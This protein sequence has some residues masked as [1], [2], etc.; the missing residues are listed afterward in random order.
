MLR[1][2]MVICLG[3]VGLSLVGAAGASAAAGDVTLVSVAP[4]GVLANAGSFTPSVSADGCRVA[5]LTD[6]TNLIPG[7]NS[8][9]LV[10]RDLCAGI[11][12][13]VATRV[14]G[15]PV[16]SAD[17]STVA[18]QTTNALDPLDTNADTDIYTV[19]VDTGVVQWVSAATNGGFQ[20][21]IS[22]DGRYVA[23]ISRNPLTPADTNLANDVF[24]RDTASGTT[25][26]ASTND[27]GD[28]ANAGRESGS[29]APSISGDGRYVAFASDAT[30]LVPNDTNSQPDVF[31]RDMS[32]HTTVRANVSSGGS[33]AN[34]NTYQPAISGNGHVVAFTSNATNLVADDTN[35][36]A[37]VFVRDLAAQT[38]QR[39]SVSSTGGQS[40][41][42]GSNTTPSLSSDGRFVAF[43]GGRG[44]FPNARSGADV[45]VRDRAR[46]V[47][48]WVSYSASKLNAGPN[49]EFARSTEPMISGNGS[50][51]VFGNNDPL[52]P[53]A[54]GTQNNVWETQ[55]WAS[56]TTPP[57]ITAQTDPPAN[58]YGWYGEPPTI[59]WQ[60]TD[61]SGLAVNPPASMAGTEGEQ[62]LY[63]SDPG[64]DLIGNCATGSV[65]LSS[66][67][68]IPSVGDPSF[69]PEKKTLTGSVTISADAADTPS[70]VAGGEF[71]I[72]DDPGQGNGTPMTFADGV[73]SGT[74]SQSL[75]QGYFQI[76]V[77]SQDKAG[78]WSEVHTATLT[79]YDPSDHT[80]P[81][82]TGTP[83]SQ[84]N[85]A[86]WYPG[87]PAITWAATD[88]SGL[89]STPDPTYTDQEGRDV[90]Y[91][92][93]PS[94]DPAGNCATGTV[95]L[96]IDTTP[97]VISNITWTPTAVR[98]GSNVTITADVSDALSGVAGGRILTPWGD[99]T[100]GTYANGKLTIHITA[101]TTPGDYFMY[102]GVQAWDVAGVHSDTAS[103]S[104]PV[105][106]PNGA[107]VTGSGAL[108]P[109]SWGDTLPN[110]DGTSR[111]TFDLTAKYPNS[112][113]TTPT[114]SFSFSYPHGRFNFASTSY[115]W[116]T[117]PDSSQI[118]LQGLG[119]L[120]GSSTIYRFRLFA[121]SASAP[122]Y[123]QLRIYPRNADG[124]SPDYTYQASGN[125]QSGSIKWKA[126][127]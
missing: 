15:R 14:P 46:G 116:L 92:S 69:S 42:Y 27:N 73:I 8:R 118:T 83:D 125:L 96:S 30:N 60:A 39:V 12:K 16:I 114:G 124:D 85:D 97:P 67:F 104:L 120:G 10:V 32:A 52:S 54:Q 53:P 112:A 31:V 36:A 109:G 55:R 119:K 110:L 93:A 51:V 20:P 117:A 68:T 111:A 6:A 22:S 2:W 21:S 37:D 35:L 100:D 71:F 48:G 74:L 17:G 45:L 18:F 41:D 77:R 4:G 103:F 126:G 75:D 58:E 3:V 9:G 44:L 107:S 1:G 91:S 86:G 49:I 29:N 70:G 99:I 25:T 47:T 5:F 90:T 62:V 50:F 81:V 61:D 101:P 23:Y 63:T 102:P 94:C 122:N 78:H 106:D 72:G 34:G 57:V 113:S 89:A 76:G 13:L 56:D 24:V 38:T 33:Q 88:D 105:Y 123:F 11:T 115:E 40:V 59:N 84:P 28:V 7:A 121:S 108:I 64:C 26:L 65:A 127:R 87:F 19:N 43:L 98:A 82:V 95:T 79:V 66:D 80:P